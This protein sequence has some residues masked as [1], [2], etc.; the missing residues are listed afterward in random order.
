MYSFAVQ[1]RPFDGVVSGAGREIHQ[2]EDERARDEWCAARPSASGPYKG[3]PRRPIS[4]DE[5]Y[6]CGLERAV[7]HRR[8]GHDGEGCLSDGR[9][10]SWLRFLFLGAGSPSPRN[11]LGRRFG[12]L[13]VVARSEREGKGVY[14]VCRCDCGNLTTVRADHLTS[15]HTKSC[16]KCRRLWR[17]RGGKGEAR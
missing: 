6:D 17:K 7:V 9:E 12:H 15:G 2:F 10:G 8:C 5:A 14:W 13:T 16:G 1:D 4:V 11:R 3:C